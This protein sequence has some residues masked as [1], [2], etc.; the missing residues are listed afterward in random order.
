[1][2][3]RSNQAQL[4]TACTAICRDWNKT[5]T[6]RSQDP[7]AFS[8]LSVAPYIHPPSLKTLA[9]QETCQTPSASLQ[10][11]GRSD[12]SFRD[13]QVPFGLPK[14]YRFCTCSAASPA[15]S[16]ERQSCSQTSSRRNSNRLV[17]QRGGTSG[18]PGFPGYHDLARTGRCKA[19]TGLVFNMC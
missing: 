7:K 16:K 19:C 6:R 10:E 11:A 2:Y 12:T 5:Q 18:G 4:P 13:S 14:P 8:S 17:P 3:K 9:F 1:M 15:L